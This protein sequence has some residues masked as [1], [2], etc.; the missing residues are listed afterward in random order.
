MTSDHR[1]KM[2]PQCKGNNEFWNCISN[3]NRVMQNQTCTMPGMTYDSNGSCFP[4]YVLTDMFFFFFFLSPEVYHWANL[5]YKDENSY[6]MHNIPWNNRR[7]QYFRHKI[8]SNNR[9]EQYF[10]HKIPWNNRREQYIRHKIPLN[11]RREQYFRHKIPSNNR[12]EQY[13]RHKIPWN[14]RR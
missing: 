12:R 9:G 2:G 4:Y 10:R 14:N 13:F 3:R 8:P 6:F 11:N 1:S 7:E 5:N